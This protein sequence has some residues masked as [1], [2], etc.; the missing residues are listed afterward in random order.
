MTR[1]WS[2][3]QIGCR[4]HAKS[5]AAAGKRESRIVR[6]IPTVTSDGR[7]HGRPSSCVNSSRTVR[8]HTLSSRT[9]TRF[10]ADARLRQRIDERRSVPNPTF[11][12]ARW[13]SP[14]VQE[15]TGAVSVV[16][17][18]GSHSIKVPRPSSSDGGNLADPGTS[19]RPACL[20]VPSLVSRNR[21][22]RIHHRGDEMQSFTLLV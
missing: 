12:T 3:A 5:R 2:R 21:I 6:I 14:S 15:N 11:P 18:G 10:I 16:N 22:L 1:R 7:V 17:A 19:P 8:K 13:Q 4:L 9:I 20:V